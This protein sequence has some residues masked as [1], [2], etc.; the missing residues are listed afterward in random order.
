MT[1]QTD[2]KIKD[3]WLKKY[4][5]EINLHKEKLELNRFEK[6]KEEREY[7]DKIRK[8]A[9]DEKF[10]QIQKKKNL[11]DENREEHHKNQIRKKHNEIKYL[12]DK[13]R[14]ENVSLDMHSEERL[15]NIKEYINKLSDNV[16]KNMHSYT[17]FTGTGNPYRD[18]NS[19]PAAMNYHNKNQN[20]FVS[21]QNAS[22]EVY[23]NKTNNNEILEPIQSTYINNNEPVIDY[24]QR[25][26]VR[27]E[28]TNSGVHDQFYHRNINEY[29]EVGNIHIYILF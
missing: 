28:I 11:I 2:N 19:N 17:E 27:G 16:D 3:K 21:N 4:M 10:R 12:E 1:F 18:L 9:E 24:P 5:E 15:N 20:N 22:E 7:L 26:T 6:I 14:K 25:R 23:I 29:K 13:Y 8:E